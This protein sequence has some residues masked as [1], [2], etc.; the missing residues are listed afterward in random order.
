VRLAFERDFDLFSD[1]ARYPMSFISKKPST[2]FIASC[3]SPEFAPC[4]WRCD[5]VGDALSRT[6]PNRACDLFMRDGRRPASSS[7]VPAKPCSGTFINDSARRSSALCVN[8]TGRCRRHRPLKA[9]AKASTGMHTVPKKHPHTK[10]M[11]NVT[12]EVYLERD[13]L[14]S[15]SPSCLSSTLRESQNP[16]LIIE[17]KNGRIGA[18]YPRSQN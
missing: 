3:W 5:E 16:R 18:P 17:G 9:A 15:A 13:V 6:E 12:F 8:R 4:S 2:P 11:T 10:K 1:H 14:S 7:G